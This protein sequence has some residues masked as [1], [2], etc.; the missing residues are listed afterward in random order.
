MRTAVVSVTSDLVTDRRVDNTCKELVACGFDVLL[1]GRRKTDSLSLQPRIYKTDRL[2]LIFE[3]GFLFYAEFN[4]RLFFYLLFKKTDLLYANDLDTLL[5][6][7]LVSVIRRKPLMYDSHEY[8]TGVP[9]LEGRPFV[10]KTWKTIEKFIFPKLK[11]IITVNDSIAALYKQEY[12]KDLIVVRNMPAYRELVITKTKEELGLPT[13]K[14]IVLLQGAG[15][16]VHRG[17]EEAVEAIKFVENAVLVIMGSGDVIDI[18]KK[19]A[20]EPDLEGKVIFIPKQPI[21]RLFEY[22]VHADIGLTL[23]K[24]TNINYRYSLPNKVFDYIQAG[25]PVL[26]SPLVEIKKIIDKYQTGC[27]ID[28]HEP[29]HIAQKITYMLSDPERI[30]EWKKNLKIA[31]QELCLE[32]EIENLRELL[33]RHAK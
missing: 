14:K 27:T 32:H 9:E 11:E 18:L 17:S 10:R 20:A 33:L 13:D 7:Y 16:N 3:K 5:P 24:D 6:N 30:A 25:V 2:R 12:G 26:A 29:Q 4:L 28:N 19:R 1:A 23:D 22:T 31:S 21:D 8:F 15:I